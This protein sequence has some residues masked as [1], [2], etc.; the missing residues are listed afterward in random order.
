MLDYQQIVADLRSSIFMDGQENLDFLRAAT[1]DYLVACDETNQRLLRCA[2][3]LRRGEISEALRLC[4]LEPNLLDVVAALDFPE[5]DQWEQSIQEHGLIAPPPLEVDIAADLNEAYARAQP[6]A[7]TLQRHRL[8]AISRAPIKSRLQVLRQLAELDQNNAFWG[9]DVEAFEKVRH[10]EL[11]PAVAAAVQTKNAAA[12]EELDE[13]LS[14]GA[15]TVPPPQALVRRVKDT[16]MNLYRE[17][18]RAAM[19]ILQGELITAYANG[20]VDGGRE[21]RDRWLELAP[22]SGLPPNHLLLVETQPALEWLADQDAHEDDELA[23]MSAAGVLKRALDSEE[24]Q[25][26]LQRLHAAALRN[27]WTLAADLDHRYQTRMA[28]FEAARRRRWWLVGGASAALFALVA[29]GTILLVRAYMYSRDVDAQCA[30]AEQLMQEGKLDEAEQFFDNLSQT[31]PELTQESKVHASRSRLNELL[32]KEQA[33]HKAFMERL[34]TV[35]DEAQKWYNTIPLK[36]LRA[37]AVTAGEKQSLEVAINQVVAL[38]AQRQELERKRQRQEL[39]ALRVELGNLPPT[40]RIARLEGLRTRLATLNPSLLDE[41]RAEAVELEE[42]VAVS[43]QDFEQQDKAAAQLQA[44]ERQA[45]GITTEVGNTEQFLAQ[46]NSYAKAHDGTPR[47]R[48]FQIVLTDGGLLAWLTARNSAI[49]R[50]AECAQAPSPATAGEVATL[51]GAFAK[52]TPKDPNQARY[53][54]RSEYYQA[55]ASRLK[56]GERIEGDFKAWLENPLQASCKLYTHETRRYYSLQK[57]LVWEGQNAVSVRYLKDSSQQI[58]SIR[59]PASVMPGSPASQNSVASAVIDVLTKLNDRDW[60]GQFFSA[61]KLIEAKQAPVDVDPILKL[62]ML[63]RALRVACSGGYCLKAAFAGNLRSLEDANVD[64]GANWL[65]PDD[66]KV[67]VLRER[68]AAV[69]GRLIPLEEGKKPAAAMLEQ[70]RQPLGIQY[71][72]IGWLRKRP[73]DHWTCE[74]K[75]GISVEKKARLFVMVR[76]SA[77]GGGEVVAFQIVG[78]PDQVPAMPEQASYLLEGRP[79]LVAR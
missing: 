20:D 11:A 28:Q 12:L 50:E 4:E 46:L 72:W 64:D 29:L 41:F 32:I 13:E 65:S 35:H 9:E 22:D 42:K 21:H 25:A 16:R 79:V 43:R 54:Q 62:H 66:A 76:Q 31:N 5:R 63:R 47:A 18:V 77:A 58:A 36:E 73:D 67:D 33:R 3:L 44:A 74:I 7:A 49:A 78:T 51:L 69:L 55:I 38:D 17:S 24:S 2:T 53:Q 40:E 30:L 71:Q 15:W 26:D 52:A 6:L 27:G 37:H 23:R 57:P 14:D 61:L 1:S 70:C 34:Q 48:D 59:L 60:E 39:D 68:A 19:E 45:D 10:K 56:D 8:L 75:P